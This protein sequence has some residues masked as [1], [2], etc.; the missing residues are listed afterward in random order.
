[1]IE[2]ATLYQMLNDDGDDYHYI[3]YISRTCCCSAGCY[4]DTIE[5][6]EGGDWIPLDVEC[7]HTAWVLKCIIER[8]CEELYE[9]KDIR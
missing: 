5:I 9:T 4:D 8:A 6:N 7:S 3:K 2:T 1:M